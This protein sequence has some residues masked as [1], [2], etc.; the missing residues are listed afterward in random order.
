VSV[1][2]SILGPL[3]VDII[4]A[5]KQLVSTF[6]VLSGEGIR[7]LICPTYLT[8]LRDEG[9]PYISCNAASVD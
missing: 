4:K 1:V 9:E 8:L 7:A 3:S 2:T 5:F 6:A